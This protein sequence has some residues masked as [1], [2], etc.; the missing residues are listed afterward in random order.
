MNPSDKPFGTVLITGASGGIGFEMAKLIAPESDRLILVARPSPRLEEAA[1]A[2]AGGAEIVVLPVDLSMAGSAAELL[3]A[4]VSRGLTI[5]TLINNAGSG[6][7]GPFAEK[8][9]AEQLAMIELNITSLVT[10]TRGL[11]PGMLARKR[12]RILN[13]ASTAAYQAGPW[14]TVYY[15]TKSFVLSF[16]EGL[17]HEL[18]GTGVTVTALCPGPTATGFQAKA[19]MDGLR[20]LEMGMTM[21]AQ[22]VAKAAI[23]GLHRGSATVIPGLINK[24]G[25]WSVKFSPRFL[26]IP[27]LGWLNGKKP[28]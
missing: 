22:S 8:G 13:V 20:V 21:D 25:V 14:M 28:T 16:S 11:L 24:L 6:V 18:R 27:V 2:L 1:K 19:K 4:L 9:A 12:G 15:A 26:V 7:L 10:L 5:D 3:A 17:R 23:D